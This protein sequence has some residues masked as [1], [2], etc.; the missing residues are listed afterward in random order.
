MW[1]MTMAD[2]ESETTSVGHQRPK[3]KA[4]EDDAETK[5]SEKSETE[6]GKEE[7]EK[8]GKENDTDSDE[9]SPEERKRDLQIQW[10]YDVA[11]L[12]Q[13]LALKQD[14]KSKDDQASSPYLEDLEEK[15]VRQTGLDEASRQRMKKSADVFWQRTKL[16]FGLLA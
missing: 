4:D 13:A 3:K 12:Q 1:N 10:L 5:D 15:L 6:E 7:E 2:L 9:P 14:D 8:D 16:L 11:Y